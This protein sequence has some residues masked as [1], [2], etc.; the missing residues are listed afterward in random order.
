MEIP[1]TVAMLAALATI[2]HLLSFITGAVRTNARVWLGA[3]DD[4]MLL[5]CM[6]A[7]SNFIENALIAIILIFVLEMQGHA[8]VSWVAWSATLFV[9]GRILHPIGFIR[10]RGE[11]VPLRFIGMGLGTLASIS[12][13]SML[14]YFM[15]WAELI[16]IFK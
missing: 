11:R 6:R 7:H 5:A 2:N 10:S 1:I 14:V 8:P 4:K 12:M 3:G 15:P 13:I 9:V 16:H